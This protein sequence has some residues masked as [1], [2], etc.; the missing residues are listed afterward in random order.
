MVI[1]DMDES[2]KAFGRVLQ[3]LCSEGVVN[4]GVRAF[5]SSK[6]VYTFFKKGEDEEGGDKSVGRATDG[7]DIRT[8]RI[9][10]LQLVTA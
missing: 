8:P 5:D 6:K 4:L 9:S 7:S 3:G 2:L 1:S 10:N